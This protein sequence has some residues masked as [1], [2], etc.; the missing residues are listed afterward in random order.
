MSGETYAGLV[1]QALRGAADRVVLVGEDGTWSGQA[2]CAWLW[3]LRG[4][5][6]QCA[7]EHKPAVAILSHN[8]PDAWLAQVATMAAGGCITWLHPRGSVADHLAV[9]NGSAPRLLLLDPSFSPAVTEPLAERFRA[10]GGVVASLGAS[11]LGPD[12]HALAGAQPE[13]E[14]ELQCLP[15]EVGLLAY[16]GGTTGGP[17][18]VARTHGQWA[19]MARIIADHCE[20]GEGSRF[21]AASPLSHVGGTMVL[22]VLLKGG[23]VRMLAAPSAESI[24]EALDSWAATSTLLVPTALDALVSHVRDS[25]LRLPALRRVYYGGAPIAPARLR[26]ASEVL[27]PVLFQVYGQAEGFPICVLPP[28]ALDPSIEHRWRSCGRPVGS[29]E[30][31]IATTDGAEAAPGTV[32]ELLARGPQ[33]MTG[34]WKREDASRQALQGGW[35]HTGDLA[36]LHDDGFVELV[37][38][39][40]DMIISG[41]FNVYAR[42]VETTLEA[43]PAIEAAA[44]F[45]MADPK[46]GEAVT[47]CVVLR[48]GCVATEAELMD[49]VRRQRGA[50]QAPKRIGFAAVLPLTSVGKVD[51]RALAAR[52]SHT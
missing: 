39:T 2:A 34:Y 29:T 16:T 15:D 36:R 30:I 11:G 12:V 6:R 32:G 10:T 18:A 41:G 48:P 17:K 21:L 50:Y 9:L 27:G 8:R 26:R 44:V 40:R 24:R 23:C 13:C 1:V 45:G 33:V 42:D 28:S 31:R 52:A 46:W 7:S 47:A 20:L 51:K 3:R 37:G 22:P 25:G 4:A 49:W 14:K 38:R 43:H 5:L 19:A 35:L